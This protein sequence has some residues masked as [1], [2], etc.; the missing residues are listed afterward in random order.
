MSTKDW[1]EKDFYKVLGV[2]KDAKRRRDQEGLPQARARQPPRLQPGRRR[3]RGAVQG[4]LRGLRR[5]R[6]TPRSARS[7]TRQRA[8]FG[9]GGFRLP[10]GGGAPAA[11]ASSA[12]DDCSATRGDGGLGDL[13][14]GL[15]GGGRTPTARSTAR[16]PG[17]AATSR[18]RSTVDF[19][20]GDRG[21]H[22]RACG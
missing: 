4:D 13:F 11:R 16:G 21:R 1:V 15:F 18:P 2:T 22:R 3:G 5:A 14:G 12:V 20:R 7:T 19:E 6:R 17:A 9:G 10:G 8:L